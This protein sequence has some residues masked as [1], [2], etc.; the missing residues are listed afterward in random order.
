MGLSDHSRHRILTGFSELIEATEEDDEVEIVIEP[1]LVPDER[2]HSVAAHSTIGSDNN[3]ESSDTHF[4]NGVTCRYY[5]RS[6]CL[7]ANNCPYSHGPDLY[8]LRSHPECVNF[9]P[10]CSANGKIAHN[11]DR[12]R[13]VCMYFIHNN[14]CRFKDSQCNYSHRRQDLTWNDEELKQQLAGKLEERKN[15]LRTKKEEHKMTKPRRATPVLPKPP[16]PQS[17]PQ[18]QSSNKDQNKTPKGGKTRNHQPPL[19]VAGMSA[20]PPQW[21]IQQ[22]MD[23]LR[24]L[25]YGLMNWVSD[26]CPTYC[27]LTHE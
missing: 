6:R 12:G 19:N 10:G 26:I 22:Q 11:L 13:N 15:H 25:Q 4:G 14:K 23:R 20:Y 1:T 27:S 24:L 8:S 7:K 2:E 17:P 16:L 5:N 21:E 9:L 3:A 18:S